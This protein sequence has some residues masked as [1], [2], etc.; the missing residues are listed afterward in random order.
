MER[1]VARLL[2]G[3]DPDDLSQAV[4]V[5]YSTVQRWIIG[6]ALPHRRVLP[7]LSVATGIEIED[8]RRA[9]ALD[10]IVQKEAEAPR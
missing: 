7:A 5:H 2:A 10:R 4:G 3:Q 1:H 6:D 9:R 8:L